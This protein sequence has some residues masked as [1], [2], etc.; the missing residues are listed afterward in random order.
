VEITGLIS[1]IVIG[2][3]IGGLGRLVAPGRKQVSLLV[4]MLVGI[5]AAVAGTAVAGF[6]GVADTSGIDWSE[7][8]LQVIFSGGV[9]SLLSRERIRQ[10]Q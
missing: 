3:V 1:A 8:A 5:V 9:V 7:L 2:L 4:T 10:H 6:I